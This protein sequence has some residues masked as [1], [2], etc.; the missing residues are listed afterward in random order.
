MVTPGE[1]CPTCGLPLLSAVK[2]IETSYCAVCNG[3]V[4]WEWAWIREQ[5]EIAFSGVP[6]IASSP[7]A[8]TLG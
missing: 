3:D 7:P 1:R 6:L 5:V 2:G 4:L 8:P